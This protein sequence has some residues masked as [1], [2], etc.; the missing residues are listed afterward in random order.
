[1]NGGTVTANVTQI[2][3][4]GAPILFAAGFAFGA[5]ID[6]QWQSSTDN[7]NWVNIPGEKNPTT[8]TPPSITTTTYYRLR[9]VCNSGEPGYSTTRQIPVNNPS[10]VSATNTALRCGVGTVTLNAS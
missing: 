10:V 6:Y 4:A 5:G 9:V 2:C 3:N 1:N 7:I 8:A